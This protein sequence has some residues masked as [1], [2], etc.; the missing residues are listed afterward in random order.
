LVL[1][2]M[3]SWRAGG[4]SQ[5]ETPV[6]SE[7]FRPAADAPEPVRQIHLTGRRGTRIIWVLNPAVRF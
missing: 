7:S 1:V 2:A 3:E 4:W 6:V 5:G